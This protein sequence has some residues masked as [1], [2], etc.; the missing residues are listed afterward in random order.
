ML[1]LFEMTHPNCAWK[2]LSNFLSGNLSTHAPVIKKRVKG[3]F[4][5]WLTPEVKTQNVK[6]QLYRKARKHSRKGDW[7]LYKIAK[8]CC[9]NI[10]E[11]AK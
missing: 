1:P 4:C 11:S 6:D 9:N 5:P 2:F 8:N 3:R 10:A 7:E